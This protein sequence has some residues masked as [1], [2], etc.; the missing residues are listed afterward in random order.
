MRKALAGTLALLRAA[1]RYDIT[2]GGRATYT[3]TKEVYVSI[4]GTISYQK[5]GGGTDAYIFYIY[6]N[7]ILLAG[8]GFD[9]TSGGATADGVAAMNYGSS[10][11]QN[12]YIDLKYKY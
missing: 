2:T 10:M 12:D 9:V 4:H 11:N 3:A 7:G 1:V 8:S 5:Q 6:K